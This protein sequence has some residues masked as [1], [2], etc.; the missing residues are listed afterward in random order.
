MSLVLTC[1]T[2]NQSID[3]IDSALVEWLVK[4]SGASGF[5]IIHDVPCSPRGRHGCSWHVHAGTD[6]LIQQIPA[7][8]FA[9]PKLLQEA[10]NDGVRD[11]TELSATLQ[12]LS[13]IARR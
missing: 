12:I 5:R 3:G 10:L 4:D 7:A 1:A 11:P 6:D 13:E 2:C 8:E 9:N